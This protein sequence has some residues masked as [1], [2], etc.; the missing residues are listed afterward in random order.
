MI[1]PSCLVGADAPLPKLPKSF[2][3]EIDESLA[4][5]LDLGVGSC[6]QA[7]IYDTEEAKAACR[8]RGFP[9]FP[10]RIA[11][12][13]VRAFDVP[14]TREKTGIKLKNPE[15][16]QK[17]RLRVT[18]R[19]RAWRMWEIRKLLKSEGVLPADY[20]TDPE[21]WK[22]NPSRGE[23]PLLDRW[24]DWH[25]CMTKGVSGVGVMS[26]LELRVR[27]LDTKLGP[28]EWAAVLLHV[29]K[30][31]GFKSNRKS[32]SAD[33]EGGKVLKALSE[34]KRRMA[35]GSYRT[36]G[37]MLLKHSDFAERKRN[38]EGIYVATPLR[39]EQEN[40]VRMLFSQQR[41]LGNPNTGEELEDSYLRLFNAQYALQ[42]P[43]NLLGDCPF[44]KAEKRSPRYAPSFELSRAL[45]KLNTLW[46]IPKGEVKVRL[47]DHVD[48]ANG[49]YEDF[50]KQFGSRGTKSEPGRI[51]WA[52]LRSI[53]RLHDELVFADL[54]T[55]KRK[56]KK[57]GTE[58]IQ[59]TE[60]LEKEDFVTRNNANAAA[61][62][63]Y[64]LRNALRDGLYDSLAKS[65]PEQLD[66]TAFALSFFE[67]IENDATTD[68]YWGV[69]NQMRADDLDARLIEDIA[70]DL[71]SEKPSLNKFS[72]TTSMSVS[73]CRRLIPHLT[74][75][76][77]YSEACSAEYGDHRQTDLN[78][79]TIT[80]P[81]VKSVVRECLK[82][83]VHLIDE[84]G[85]IPGRICV[86]IGRDLGKSVDERN[87]MAEGIRERT[88]AKNANRENL[89][90]HLGRLPDDDELLRY[91]LWLEQGN[92][93]PYCGSH[94]GKP[95]DIVSPEFEI[96]HILPRSRS[97]D[98]SYENKVLVHRR[99]NRDKKDSTPFEFHRIGNRDEHSDG[100]RQFTAILSTLKGI[101]KQKRRNLLNTT[102]GE[103]ETKFASRHLNDT[104]YIAKLVTHYLHSL[105][106]IAGE[107][108]VTAKGGKKRV[109]VQPG[110]LT[111]IVRKAWGLENLKKDVEGNRI[112]DKHHAI[113]ALVCALLSD[114]QRQFVTR[115]D[116][117]DRD[118][119][120]H[121]KIFT[122]F[123]RHYRLMEDANDQRRVP[124]KMDPPWPDF[125]HDVARAV[126]LFTV[127]RREVRK[128]R[129]GLHNDTIYRVGRE[130]GKDVCYSRKPII[131]TSVGKGKA[132]FKN[133]EDLQRIKDIGSERNGWL[134]D[135][136]TAWIKAGA[137]VEAHLLP[138]DPQGAIIRK[139][140]LN[141]GKK[142]GRR[143]PQGFVSGGD[144]VRL[145]VFSK[146]K[147]NGERNFFLVPI[148]SY[149][150]SMEHPPV[151]AIVANKDEEEWDAVDG[152]FRFEFSLWP[153]SRFEIVKKPTS[154]KPEGESVIG[155]YAGIDRNTGAFT[156]VDPDDSQTQGRLTAKT[157]ATS[158]RKLDTDR[159]GRV[160]LIDSE[161]RTWRGG[162][163]T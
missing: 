59:T 83:V 38:R 126:E 3:I 108:P 158:F 44:E 23:N 74:I 88:D 65:Q 123:S 117:Q 78:F 43:L 113:D 76:V 135:S 94:L 162:T 138:R 130:N 93:C 132:I 50:I 141:Q 121:S 17:R 82:Q 19:R 131:D 45:Q 92:H 16:R 20:P 103:D 134:R 15:R 163:I 77:V 24:R 122:D 102:F 10:E 157:G 60:K 37:E 51:T 129:G 153:K 146:T 81:V 142:S 159:L 118:A 2:P 22:K 91:E 84:A 30:H 137:P 25:S 47:A 155:L 56:L 120:R 161:K 11:F 107:T 69:L 147:A 41:T 6:G 8:I 111:A 154:L 29:A 150:L 68:K 49:G 28:L 116:Q 73:A 79:D 110:G 12:L 18:T 115:R 46:V 87:A 54:P 124:G 32:E 21:I 149:H 42:N 85:K 105:Y 96:D 101:R 55:P 80:N 57:D 9:R 64:L 148:Y 151:R 34:N 36:I 100:W 71:R 48:A 125:R 1:A 13:G 98:N 27:G 127:S 136:L 152:T 53:F 106:E 66:R 95:S 67:Q 26:P 90:G 7:L 52:D 40:E 62:G 14:E 144:Q 86:E 133:L 128:G 145:D 4:L 89:K 109:F 31:R 143:Y 39:K 139:V 63:T 5:G 160:N 72:G 70:A 156:F 97:F 33:E 99:C 119:L 114:G 35:E 112:G 104:R 58:E 61:K 75:G 140:T